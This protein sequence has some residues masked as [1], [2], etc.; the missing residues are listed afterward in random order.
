MRHTLRLT[1]S[2]LVALCSL[3]SLA[4]MASAQSGAADRDSMFQWTG[5]MAA[6]TVLRVF[7][8]NG[9]INAVVSSDGFAEVKAV[10]RGRS[11][12]SIRD[13]RYSELVFE[14]R[15]VGNDIVICVLGPEDDC[16]DDGVTRHGR[17]RDGRQRHADVTIRVPKG[18]KLHVVS[19]NGAVEAE[20]TGAGV[21]ARSGNG[22]VRVEA[23][24]DSV[25][26]HSG[27][28]DIDV[29]GAGGP[30]NAH[31]GNGRIEVTTS[32]GP[33]QA[34]TGN[35]SIQ[36]EMA[37]LRGSENM[38]FRSGNGRVTVTLPAD[39]NG[40][41]ESSTGNGHLV[42]DF[43][44]SVEGRLD[45]Q[46]VRATIGK[47]GPRLRITSGNGNLVLRKAGGTRRER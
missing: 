43:P 44:L 27:N 16:D 18:V 20:G 32:L 39:Y 15:R 26:A 23:H 25:V 40:E 14:T 2:A 9:P 8:V 17:S 46:R 7:S 22:A 37:A 42:S 4:T 29:R 12:R 30:V 28:G 36:V 45:R 6:G 5:Q 3:A 1:F 19:G 47:G 38:S 24:G 31:S 21:I 13:D 35:G 33:V 11:G 34:T 10:K 41:L